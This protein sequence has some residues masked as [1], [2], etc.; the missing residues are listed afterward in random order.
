[1]ECRQPDVTA[2]SVVFPH[3]WVF[4]GGFLSSWREQSSTVFVVLLRGDEKEQKQRLLKDNTYCVLFP[5]STPVPR[6][7]EPQLDREQRACTVKTT[8]VRVTCRSRV[9]TDQLGGITEP[10]G[11]KRMMDIKSRNRHLPLNRSSFDKIELG[12]GV[13]TRAHRYVE[14]KHVWNLTLCVALCVPWYAL[15]RSIELISLWKSDLQYVC[16]GHA[17]FWILTQT[18][19]PTITK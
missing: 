16:E 4:P 2:A 3:W 18:L 5:Q 13:F 6:T 17:L 14:F 7:N 11:L 1:V 12:Y 15:F 8:G 10:I 9:Y 19:T